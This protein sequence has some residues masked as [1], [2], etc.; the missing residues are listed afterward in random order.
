M[1]KIS[2]KDLDD[3][4]KKEIEGCGLGKLPSNIDRILDK[5]KDRVI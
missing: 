4:P 3:T 1:P 5:N 2:F